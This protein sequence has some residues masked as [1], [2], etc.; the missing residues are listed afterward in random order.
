MNPFCLTPVDIPRGTFL[1]QANIELPCE[2]R[3]PALFSER[4][5]KS[6]GIRH[7]PVPERRTS[8][9][10]SQSEPRKYDNIC[11][12]P[13]SRALRAVRRGVLPPD[14]L[15]SCKGRRSFVFGPSLV[16]HFPSRRESNL[17]LPT[18]KVN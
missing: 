5:G 11:R 17:K 13:I 1:R 14:T 3:I 18:S 9:I 7:S 2:K 4:P 10:S 15:F 6:T 12:N 16:I 8:S